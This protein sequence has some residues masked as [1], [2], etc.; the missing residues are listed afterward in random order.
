MDTVEVVRAMPMTEESFKKSIAYRCVKDVTLPGVISWHY[1]RFECSCNV[2]MTIG[3]KCLATPVHNVVEAT[4][5]TGWKAEAQEPSCMLYEEARKVRGRWQVDVLK[6]ARTWV[7]ST[8]DK[9]R[10]WQPRKFVAYTE[11]DVGHGTLGSLGL[12][13]TIPAQRFSTTL[14][15]ENGQT[16][17]VET[18]QA[19]LRS[20]RAFIIEDHKQLQKM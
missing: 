9:A 11:V 7:H 2:E 4:G 18:I 16:W 1:S 17:P 6:T 8:T 14:L 20:L 19:L 15:E 3:Y 10:E 5:E 12:G 13:R